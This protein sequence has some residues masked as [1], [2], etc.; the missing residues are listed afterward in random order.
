MLVSKAGCKAEVSHYLS[1][2]MRWKLWSVGHT[3]RP[4]RIWWGQLTK[5]Q[6]VDAMQDRKL[7]LCIKQ[8]H[9]KDV[10]EALTSALEIEAF[11]C[12][13][14]GAPATWML[15]KAFSTHEFWVR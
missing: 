12:T 15:Q 13:S 6:L 14:V 5:D 11:L 1:W 10:C 4:L 7:Q 3:Q 2:S 8:A 9:P